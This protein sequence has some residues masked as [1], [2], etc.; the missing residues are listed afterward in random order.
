MS[1]ARAMQNFVEFK[2]AFDKQQKKNIQNKGLGE[3]GLS[4]SR[5]MNLSNFYIRRKNWIES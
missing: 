4:D 5:W 3:H 1:F 2:F